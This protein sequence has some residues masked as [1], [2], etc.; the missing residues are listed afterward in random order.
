MRYRIVLGDADPDKFG[1]EE[2]EAERLNDALFHVAS[3]YSRQPVELWC[4]D[5]YLGRLK[6]MVDA[7][8]SYWKLA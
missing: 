5:T 6:H 1:T 3:F 2:F 7:E 8:A 4:D